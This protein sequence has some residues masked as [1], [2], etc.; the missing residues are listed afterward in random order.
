MI[1]FVR[2]R[3]RHFLRQELRKILLDEHL[4]YG[5]SER[6]SIAPTAIVNNAVFNTVSGSISVGDF[7]F[8]GHNVALLTGSHDVT[9]KKQARR[10]YAPST[11]RDIIVCPGAWLGSNATVLGPCTVGEDSVIA[12]GSVVT[13]D[14]PPGV[15]VAGVPARIVKSIHFRTTDETG[16]HVSH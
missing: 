6:V 4:I 11:G 1:R 2:N 16:P 3:I 15:I 9:L 5:S 7:V 13:H 12:A 8:F 10:D 14:V